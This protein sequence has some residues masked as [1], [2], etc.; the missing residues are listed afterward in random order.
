MNTVAVSRNYL[1]VVLDLVQTGRLAHAYWY[2]HEDVDQLPVHAPF[3][4]QP[5]RPIHDRTTN[6]ARPIDNRGA[7]KEGES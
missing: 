2:I 4:L 1:E 6:G 3:L 5:P 7:F